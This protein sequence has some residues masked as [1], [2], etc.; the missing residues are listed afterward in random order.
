MR[1]NAPV[2]RS[3]HATTREA[4][5]SSPRPERCTAHLL[6]HRRRH[7]RIGR[8]RSARRRAALMPHE[9]QP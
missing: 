8:A 7:M 9:L 5:T 4:R 2:Q 1:L 3:D 6:K